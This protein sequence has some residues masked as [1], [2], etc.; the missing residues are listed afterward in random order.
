MSGRE[1]VRVRECVR[2]GASECVFERVRECVGNSVCFQSALAAG[3]GSSFEWPFVWEGK[4]ATGDLSGYNWQ[5]AATAV[6]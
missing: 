5:G 1:S 2:E 4:A 6:S 3:D